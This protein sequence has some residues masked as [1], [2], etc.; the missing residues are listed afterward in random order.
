MIKIKEYYNKLDTNSILLWITRFLLT[1]NFLVSI[2]IRN[3]YSNS[4]EVSILVMI[5]IWLMWFNKN[6][7]AFVLMMFGLY[8][9]LIGYYLL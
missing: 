5:S 3:E 1:H 6:I 7:V 9:H 2:F 8:L 4:V